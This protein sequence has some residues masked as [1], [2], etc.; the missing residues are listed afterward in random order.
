MSDK[1]FVP[2]EPGWY[3]ATDARTGKRY[4]VLVDNGYEG[5][6]KAFFGTPAFSPD[7]TPIE[8]FR[9]WRGPITEPPAMAAKGEASGTID[10]IAEFRAAIEHVQS[11]L[12]KH[13]DQY[14]VEMYAL[15]KTAYAHGSAILDELEQL[16]G[17][18]ARVEKVIAVSNPTTSAICDALSFIRERQKAR[19]SCR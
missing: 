7:G 9:D 18:V 4:I 12:S 16:R 6:L 2:T 5:T 3:W 14:R 19:A 17:I 1:P 11:S 13:G 10:G 15:A 8:Q